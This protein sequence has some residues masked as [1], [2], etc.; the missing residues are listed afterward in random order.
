VIYIVLYTTLAGCSVLKFQCSVFQLMK[1]QI[2][3]SV[4]KL[5]LTLHLTSDTLP[6]SVQKHTESL[7]LR[8]NILGLKILNNLHV[9]KNCICYI[10]MSLLLM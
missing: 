5:K 7:V 10:L 2:L 9:S 8:I 1:T 4:F 6:H 3:V